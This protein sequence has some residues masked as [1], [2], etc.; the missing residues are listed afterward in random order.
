MQGESR[1]L[2]RP[3]PG[4]NPV[5]ERPPRPHSPFAFFQIL[6]NENEKE[7]ERERE[8]KERE[9]DRQIARESEIEKETKRESEKW[10]AP[11]AKTMVS[12]VVFCSLSLACKRD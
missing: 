10:N 9:R 3:P 12:K 1:G 11:A 4:S 8:G 5:L 7:R 2:G 6:S